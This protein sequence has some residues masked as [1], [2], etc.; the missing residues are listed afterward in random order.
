MKGIP[1]FPRFP[2]RVI[3][4]FLLIILSVASATA[5]TDHGF[6][7]N[8][9]A[10]GTQS[11]TTYPNQAFEWTLTATGTEQWSTY[12]VLGT[13]T[14]GRGGVGE[15][16]YDYMYPPSGSSITSWRYYNSYSTNGGY[17]AGTYID[18]GNNRLAIRI[19][20]GGYRYYYYGPYYYN[21]SGSFQAM[22][23]ISGNTPA[24]GPVSSTSSGT[25]IVNAMEGNKFIASFTPTVAPQHGGSVT[26]LT[27]TIADNNADVNTFI[28]GTD[29]YAATS[30][31]AQNTVPWCATQS[32][33]EAVRAS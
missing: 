23:E 6:T 22:Y 31:S 27:R 28:S 12:A 13:Q 32:G 1:I 9:T 15:Y 33:C 26:G 16:Y 8:I 21:V 14:Y 4:S 18:T 29:I 11:Q 3:I 24:S 7:Y 10:T 19:F 30:F 2:A 25:G 5:D 20:T 17:D